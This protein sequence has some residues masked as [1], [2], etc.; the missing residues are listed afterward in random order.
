VLSTQTGPAF[1]VMD[2]AEGS[3]PEIVAKSICYRA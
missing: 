2:I 1:G 3:D